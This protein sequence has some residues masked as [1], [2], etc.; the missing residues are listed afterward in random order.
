MNSNTLF[1]TLLYCHLCCMQFMM[2]EG[3]YSWIEGSLCLRIW[4]GYLE[5]R[6]IGP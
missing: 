1:H 6:A 5:N 3:G 4:G 2:V